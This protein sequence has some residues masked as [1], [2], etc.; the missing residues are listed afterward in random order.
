MATEHN[1]RFSPL[2]YNQ[3]V[4]DRIALVAD[5]NLESNAAIQSWRIVALCKFSRGQ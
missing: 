3:Y 5:N 4:F 1:N 2:I